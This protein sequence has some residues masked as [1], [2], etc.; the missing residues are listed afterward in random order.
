MR[1]KDQQVDAESI[2]LCTGIMRWFGREQR[3]EIENTSAE[4][5]CGTGRQVGQ[6]TM[7]W[8]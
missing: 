5:Y 4:G 2:R 7:S 6:R 3:C 1:V 8:T